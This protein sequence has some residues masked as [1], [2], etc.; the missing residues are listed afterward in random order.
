MI[1]SIIRMTIPPEKHTDALKILSAMA[2]QCRD[3]L[4]CIGCNIYKDLKEPNVLMIEE[5]WSTQ[6]DLD[7]HLRSK[8]YGILLLVLEMALRQPE[9]KFHTIT[10]STG[11]ETIKKLR[12]Q[13]SVYVQ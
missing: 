13:R 6:E 10:K 1:L 11:I 9:I 12:S 4:G 8:E 5:I 7:V 3:Y 2:E